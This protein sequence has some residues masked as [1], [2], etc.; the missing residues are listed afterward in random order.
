[1]N[2]VWMVS[3]KKNYKNSEIKNKS[4]SGNINAET[5]SKEIG[6]QEEIYTEV[7]EVRFYS[8][9]MTEKLKI[10]LHIYRW[11]PIWM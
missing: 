3:K 4:D 5:G 7:H 8:E 1:M 10:C 9:N 6:I 2:Y 11:K